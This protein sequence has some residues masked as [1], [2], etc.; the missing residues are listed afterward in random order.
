MGL[1]FSSLLTSPL[2]W[3]ARSGPKPPHG[4]GFTITFG[5]T[6]PD[7]TPLNEWS[8]LQRDFYLKTHNTHERQAFMPPAGFEPAI[9]ARERPQ[10]HALDPR[11][12]GTGRFT[13][14]QFRNVYYVALMSPVHHDIYLPT[15]VLFWYEYGKYGIEVSTSCLMFRARRLF[16]SE[17]RVVGHSNTHTERMVIYRLRS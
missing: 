17:V 12:L 5:R 10:T 4:R 2:G 14:N 13:I 9:P 3:T 6:V 8:A 7:G 16:A 15:S 11:P 1:Q